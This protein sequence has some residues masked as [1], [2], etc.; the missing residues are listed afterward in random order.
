MI[1][2]PAAAAKLRIP[3]IASGGIGTGHGMAAALCLGA[4]AVNMGTR[5]CA[6][7]EAP[8]HDNIKQAL[9]AGTERDTNVIMRGLRNTARVLKNDVSNEVVAIE[10]AAAT[11]EFESIRHLVNGQRGRAALEAGKPDD[12]IV[13]AGLVVGLI[14]DVP[15]CDELI[16]RMVRDC[17]RRLAE[18]GSCFAA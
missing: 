12:G 6:T 5:F 16:Q 13:W 18:I 8:I 7:Q 14:E 2:I 4:S 15:S 11:P 17:R 3:V 9:V 10:R 1:L